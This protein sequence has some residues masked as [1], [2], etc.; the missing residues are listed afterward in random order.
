MEEYKQ[1]RRVE[2]EYANRTIDEWN[3]RFTNFI[4]LVVIS[5]IL[6]I[7][8]QSLVIEFT[9]YNVFYL[10]YFFM[11]ENRP[12]SYVALVT[13]E[14]TEL[15]ASKVQLESTIAFYENQLATT[16]VKLATLMVR[17]EEQNRMTA[18]K[19]EQNRTTVNRI[20]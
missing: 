20:E 7:I 5:N 8:L 14:N 3:R 10:V 1:N 4:I 19:I 18:N 16:K 15:K 2:V 13:V 11:Q 17:M 12:D 6:Y 9:S